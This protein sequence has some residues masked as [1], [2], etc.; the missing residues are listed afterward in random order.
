M[1]LILIVHMKYT[2]NAIHIPNIPLLETVKIIV[3]IKIA[4]LM[5]ND[6]LPFL[7]KIS[8]DITVGIIKHAAKKL[9]SKYVEISLSM[10]GSGFAKYTPIL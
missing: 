6:F 7:Q 5:R 1:L 2:N 3:I 9:G 10:C 4:N 8:D